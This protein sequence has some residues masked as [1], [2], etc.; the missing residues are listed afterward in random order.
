MSTS[1][2]VSCFIL[3]GSIFSSHEASVKRPPY[4]A[5]EAFLT[6]GTYYMKYRNYTNDKLFGNYSCVSR[7]GG[8]DKLEE[9]P[10]RIKYRLENYRRDPLSKQE[11]VI[12]GFYA[13]QSNTFYYTEE[14]KKQQKRK[15]I[16]MNVSEQCQVTKTYNTGN[17]SGCTLWMGAFKV[18]N[19]PPTRCEKAYKRC[20]GETKLQYHKS[21][22]HLN[23][24]Q[25][26]GSSK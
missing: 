20:G 11:D 8:D 18:D 7:W 24:W 16:Y 15:L 12:V 17:G 26:H 23:S 4:N 22:K 14:S 2:F 1:L 19:D 3:A 13:N 9:D 10:I 5:T 25:L 21:C 6:N